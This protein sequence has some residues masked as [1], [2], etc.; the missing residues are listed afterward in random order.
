MPRSFK[1]LHFA[2]PIVL[3]PRASTRDSIAESDDSPLPTSNLLLVVSGIQASKTS[4]SNREFELFETHLEPLVFFFYAL[5]IH[6]TN[7]H[8][9]LDYNTRR[10]S[11]NGRGH[12]HQTA[13]STRHTLA[14][15]PTTNDWA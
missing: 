13:T 14:P 7:V 2:T 15:Q 1:K 11:N 4:R 5:C 9:Q 8:L 6:L 10:C 12:Y 3:Q